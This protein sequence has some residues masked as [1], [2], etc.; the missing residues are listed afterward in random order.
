MKKNR[1]VHCFLF[2]LRFFTFKKGFFTLT[3]LITKW[4]FKKLSFKRFF[5]E[6]SY[7]MASLWKTLI[8]IFIFKSAFVD[9]NPAQQYH[10]MT[11]INEENRRKRTCDSLALLKHTSQGITNHLLPYAINA[12]ACLSLEKPLNHSWKS[13][14]TELIWHFSVSHTLW[15]FVC[16]NRNGGCKI[17]SLFQQAQINA[18]SCCNL[19]R[20]CSIMQLVW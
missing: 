17:S 10:P 15:H 20:A 16:E 9:L 14:W 2:M 13:D 19:R 4:I 5:T 6:S 8:V 12:A 11:F 1:N 7:I 18:S 3:H